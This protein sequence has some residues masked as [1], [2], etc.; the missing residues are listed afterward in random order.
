MFIENRLI[1]GWFGWEKNGVDKDKEV[2]AVEAQE[3]VEE[4]YMR[5]ED[6]V[7]TIVVATG[8]A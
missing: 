4:Q 3:G 8:D 7:A 5:I 1:E 6:G 2:G